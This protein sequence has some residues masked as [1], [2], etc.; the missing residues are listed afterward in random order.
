MKFYKAC[1]CLEHGSAVERC[2]D[3]CDL[4]KLLY[5]LLCLLFLLSAVVGACF[6]CLPMS[7]L[8]YSCYPGSGRAIACVKW[9]SGAQPASGEFKSAI[10]LM[11]DSCWII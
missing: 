6:I 1:L 9:F 8:Y 2:A 7:C 5:L 10:L 4:G 3:I 11:S